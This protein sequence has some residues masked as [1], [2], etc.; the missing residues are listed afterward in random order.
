MTTF[1]VISA[2]PRSFIA[3]EFEFNT[4]AEALATVADE[5]AEGWTAWIV[6]AEAEDDRIARAMVAKMQGARI[7]RAF[8]KLMA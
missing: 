5:I 4:L 1:T 6:D 3:R 8:S 7:G 2:S